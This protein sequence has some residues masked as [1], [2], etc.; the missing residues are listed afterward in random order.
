MIRMGMKDRFGESGETGELM[1]KYG[2]DKKAIIAK[3]K[4][5]SR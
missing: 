3:I 1:V 5:I 2:L 4:E